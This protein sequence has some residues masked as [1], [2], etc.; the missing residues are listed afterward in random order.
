MAWGS[1]YEVLGVARSADRDIIRAAYRVLAK[2]YHPDTT[3]GLKDIAAARFRKLQDAYEVLSDA[4]RRA[5]YDAQ[6]DAAA[7]EPQAPQAQCP[8]QEPPRTPEPEPQSHRAAPERTSPP[9]SDTGAGAWLTAGAFIIIV[10]VLIT[11]IEIIG[12]FEAPQLLSKDWNG[13]LFLIMWFGTLIWFAR[14]VSWRRY[15]NGGD[16]LIVKIATPLFMLYIAC[17]FSIYEAPQP[18]PSGTVLRFDNQGN[19][20][21]IMPST[22][23]AGLATVERDSWRREW[24]CAE[25]VPGVNEWLNYNEQAAIKC[26]NQRRE[27]CAYHPAGPWE[28]YQE[29]GVAERNNWRREWCARHPANR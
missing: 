4:R 25:P 26:N 28:D 20:I 21:Q 23:P 6:L 13:I 29:P 22:P 27:W 17:C 24:W 18:L 2:R 16:R 15:R 11:V 8:T 14:R 19:L 10:V 1:H 9:K 7:R 5:E 3:T 12:W